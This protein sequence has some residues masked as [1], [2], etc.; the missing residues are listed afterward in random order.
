MRYHVIIIL[1][2][3]LF[4]VSSCAQKTSDDY[5]NHQFVEEGQNSR[6]IEYDS[7]YFDFSV[8]NDNIYLLGNDNVEVY[9]DKV[10]NIMN[11]TDQT[12]IAISA[13]NNLV[14][15]LREDEIILCDENGK[16]IKTYPLN[17]I[18][19]IEKFNDIIMNEQY[20]IF[21]GVESDLDYI[22]HRVFCI[23]RK[24]DKMTEISDLNKNKT[25]YFINGISFI[26]KERLVVTAKITLD[27]FTDNNIIATFDLSKKQL[28]Y[29]R[30]LPHASDVS[31]SNGYIY[32]GDEMKVY[33]YSETDHVSTVIRSYKKDMILSDSDKDISINNRKLLVT[34]Q[35]IIYL[36]PTSKTIYFDRLKYEMDPVRI[37]APIS[38][39]LY[40]RFEDEIL[41][42]TMETR[43]PVE[44]TEL[45]DENYLDKLNLKL[46]AHDHDFD[47][48]FLTH[49]DKNQTLQGIL[50]KKFYRKLQ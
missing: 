18:D 10:G 21:Y 1:A 33:R 49:I 32:Y 28:V 35:N 29:E 4:S 17:N 3:I 9:R 15:L 25:V 12:G 38:E 20:I 14:A 8:D 46:M 42:F 22:H 41:S 50:D 11:Y 7:Y 37:I 6:T 2:V 43:V 24:D 30:E 27:Y 31:Q 39:K 19:N 48:F 13:Y 23:S 44:V 16:T 36:F 47:L 26:D 40:E 5:K 34:S 45:P